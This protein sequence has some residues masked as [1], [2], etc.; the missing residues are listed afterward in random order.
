MSTLALFLLFPAVNSTGRALGSGQFG[1][2]AEGQWNRPHRTTLRVAVKILHS[3]ATDLENVKFLQEAAIMGQF[4]HPNVVTL[5]GVVTLG[6]PVSL[7]ATTPCVHI[8]IK[9]SKKSR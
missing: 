1:E 2:V 7:I 4:A 3:G 5:Y 8:G 6:Q 9:H